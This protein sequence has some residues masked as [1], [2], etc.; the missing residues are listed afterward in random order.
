MK[1]RFALTLVIAT[2]LLMGTGGVT[3]A[4]TGSSGSGSAA[5]NQYNQPHNDGKDVAAIGQSDDDNV[6]PPS[7][8]VATASTDPGSLPF[9][10]FA[11]IPLL[12]LGVGFLTVGI[13]LRA[14]LGR[15]S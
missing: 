11:A 4:I 15:E 7:D 9:T 5:D 2:G 12:V 3:M 14:R 1:S 6:A 8:Q 10:G 13:V